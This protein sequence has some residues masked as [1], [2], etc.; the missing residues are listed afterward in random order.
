MEDRSTREIAEVLGIA[1]ATV[2]VHLHAGRQA[3]AARLGEA[4]EDEGES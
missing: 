4:I 1:E 3:L 2:R